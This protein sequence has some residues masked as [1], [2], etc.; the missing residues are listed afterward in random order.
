MV[1]ALVGAAATGFDYEL[2]AKIKKSPIYQYLLNFQRDLDNGE[3]TIIYDAVKSISSTVPLAGL[4]FPTQAAVDIVPDFNAQELDLPF[5]DVLNKC[6]TQ[7]VTILIPDQYASNARIASRLDNVVSYA[8]SKGMSIRWIVQPF[9]G[10]LN[11]Y[12]KSVPTVQQ[13]IKRESAFIDAVSKRWAPEYF[14]VVE[15]PATWEQDWGY[16]WNSFHFSFTDWQDIISSLSHAAK[17][18]NPSVE[19]W[20][21]LTASSSNDLALTPYLEEIPY[22]DGIGYDIYQDSGAS[23]SVVL[24]YFDGIKSAGKKGGVMETWL[25][26]SQTSANPGT[27]S[28]EAQWLTDTLKTA[29]AAGLNDCF[30]PWYTQRYV[31]AAQMPN[32]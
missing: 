21:A 27:V 30:L 28:G 13:V 11:V 14:N 12:G 7:Q 22:L 18:S 17:D 16:S 10:A 2:V 5:V 1:G 29:Q 6:G 24:P 20:C 31:D 3:T 19:T 26:T 8:R 9:A 23:V 15:E 32:E 25:F 4:H